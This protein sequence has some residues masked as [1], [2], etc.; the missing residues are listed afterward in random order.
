MDAS[1]EVESWVRD[2]G[3]RL[4]LE[5]V[6]DASRRCAFGFHNDLVGVITVP[7]GSDTVLFYAAVAR[8]PDGDPLPFLEM[9]L[10]R[11]LHGTAT[12][13]AT[14]GLDAFSGEIVLSQRWPWT[15]VRPDDFATLLG[16]FIGT[17][18][19]LHDEFSAEQST[20]ARPE[21]SS[22]D[23]LLANITWRV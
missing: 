14:L 19:R 3:R 5:L 18:I 4:G 16:N 10:E 7:Q 6:F 22:S 15:M 12:D 11:N 13:G 20:V 9:I 8:V 23:E 17:A 2:V 1:T 21:A